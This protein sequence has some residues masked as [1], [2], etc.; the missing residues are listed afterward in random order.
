MN[1]INDEDGCPDFITI[2]EAQILTFEP[3]YFETDSDV[4]QDRSRDML[5][6][7][8]RVLVA[9]PHLALRV[10]GYTDNTGNARANLDLSRRRAVQ[11]KR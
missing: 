3:V 8:A 9:N 7:V 4:I 6:E 5:G 10:E 1:E 2:E 11:L